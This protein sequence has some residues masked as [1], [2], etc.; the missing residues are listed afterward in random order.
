MSVPEAS[1]S[2]E[3]FLSTNNKIYLNTS[4]EGDSYYFKEKT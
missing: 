1:V 3:G 2:L 4:P